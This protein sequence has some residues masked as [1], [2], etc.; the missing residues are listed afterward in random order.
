MC[1]IPGHYKANCPIVNNDDGSILTTRTKMHLVADEEVST[2]QVHGILLNQHDEA[3]INP[4]MVLLDSASSHRLFH[5][6]KLLTNVG[7]TTNGEV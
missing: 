3:H 5:N 7:P 2:R 1:G 4:N 6:E